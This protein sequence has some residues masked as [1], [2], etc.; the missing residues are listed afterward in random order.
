[1][2]ADQNINGV[3]IIIIILD[4]SMSID[5]STI[6]NW[7]KYRISILYAINSF[8]FYVIKMGL[9]GSPDVNRSSNGFLFLYNND[10]NVIKKTRVHQ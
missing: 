9:I 1:M 2:D 10:W 7:S 4:R 3:I 8:S 6:A 5:L